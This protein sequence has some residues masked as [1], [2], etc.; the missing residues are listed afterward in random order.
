MSKDEQSP[1]TAKELFCFCWSFWCFSVFYIPILIYEIHINSLRL[2]I[3]WLFMNVLCFFSILFLNKNIY[4]WF[5]YGFTNR[6][7]YIEFSLNVQKIQT[8][9]NISKKLLCSYENWSLFWILYGFNK[10]LKN[11]ISINNRTIYEMFMTI[12]C[13]N[14]L[15]Q[16]MIC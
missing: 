8:H 7:T 11:I 5:C 13:F 12:L 4:C 16:L 6:K 14:I 10:L 15:R 3:D 2:W 1:K 9:T